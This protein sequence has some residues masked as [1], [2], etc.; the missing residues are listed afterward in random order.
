MYGGSNFPI[1]VGSN[2]SSGQLEQLNKIGI[3]LSVEK[4]QKKIFKHDT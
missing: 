3:A 2:E 4:N 1:Y